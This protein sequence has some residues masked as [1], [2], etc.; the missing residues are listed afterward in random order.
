MP[1]LLALPQRNPRCW[2]LRWSL[3]WAIHAALACSSSNLQCCPVP[4][5]IGARKTG[6]FSWFNKAGD[7]ALFQSIPHCGRGLLVQWP[8][9]SR[10]ARALPWSDGG[11]VRSLARWTRSRGQGRGPAVAARPPGSRAAMWAWAAPLVLCAGARACAAPARRGSNRVAR[12]FVRAPTR[13]SPKAPSI[14]KQ[15]GCTATTSV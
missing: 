5:L 14:V 9:T 6:L 7:S 15:S 12:S 13:P 2:R 8:R 4:R 10:G 11:R 1:P 3:G